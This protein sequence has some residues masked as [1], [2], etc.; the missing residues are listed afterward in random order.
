MRNVNQTQEKRYKYKFTKRVKNEEYIQIINKMINVINGRDIKNIEDTFQTF[1]T[2]STKG[3]S[4]SI[5]K[6]LV[7]AE[8]N[9]IIIRV[10][11]I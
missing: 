3:M 10:K 4:A 7:A 6:T 9:I 5:R 2:F 11:Q 1:A 8:K